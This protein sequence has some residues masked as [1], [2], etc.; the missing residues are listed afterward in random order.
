[1]G[2]CTSCDVDTY[3]DSDSD[4]HSNCH[5]DRYS[6]CHSNYSTCHDSNYR[7]G[8]YGGYSRYPIYQSPPA[9]KTNSYPNSYQPP[10]NPYAN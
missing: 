5:S 7:Y 8:G 4:C 3:P 6:D 2:L 1:M 9:T 10:Y